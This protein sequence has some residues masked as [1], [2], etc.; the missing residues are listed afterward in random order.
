MAIGI[1]GRG[2]PD[3]GMGGTAGSG[4]TAGTGVEG[5]FGG[6]AIGPDS[7]TGL[8][9]GYG[10]YTGPFGQQYSQNMEQRYGMNHLHSFLDQMARQYGQQSVRN[11]VDSYLGNIDSQAPMSPSYSEQAQNLNVAPAG[12]GPSQGLGLGNYGNF[13]DQ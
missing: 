10:G 8:G 7:F 13:G 2:H 11:F 9:V 12:F 6:P 1:G 3:H 5:A 4:N